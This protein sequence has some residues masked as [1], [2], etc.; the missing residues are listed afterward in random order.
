M[1]KDRDI[2][3]IASIDWDFIWQ[4]HQE[5]MATFAKNGNRVLFIENTGVRVP[6]IRDIGRLRKRLINWIKGVKGFREAHQNLY[7]YSP[8][9]L[10]FPYS[11]LARWINR[12]FL[13]GTLRKWLKLMDFNDAVVWTFLPTGTALDIIDDLDYKCLVYYCIADF[14][15]LVKKPKKV[16]KTE[17]A[18]IRKSDIIFAQGKAF[19]E[20]CRSL[21]DN[22]Y[23]F[24]FGLNTGIFDNS[25]EC[26]RDY[27]YSDIKNVKNPIIGYIGGIHRHIDFDLLEYIAGANSHWS[28]VLVGPVQTDVSSLKEFPNIFFLGKKN[29]NLLPAY[30]KEFDVCIIPYI[31]SEFT[32]TVYPTKLN[33]YHALGKP[34][35]S[36]DL[37][38]IIEFNRENGNLILIAS[39]ND[40]FVKLIQQALKEQDNRLV[41]MRIES[42]KRHSWDIRIE[43]MS[44]LI[45]E[46]IEKKK[47]SGYA[48]W[49]KKFKELYRLAR[50]RLVKLVLA[51][52]ALWLIVFY[53]P[54]VWFLAE[55][56]KIIN[57][58]SKA[59]AI[60]VFAGGVGESG[61]A[62]QGY[63][64]RVKHAA[65]LYNS[66]YARYIIFSSGFRSTFSEP[67]IMQVL[68]ISLGVPRDF[69]I[70][71]TKAG[72]TYQNVVFTSAILRSKGWNKIILVSSPYHT[73]RAAL[74]F[75][76]IVNDISV[77]FSPVPNSIFYS[78]N[79][80]NEKGKRIWK[81]INLKQIRGI[82]HEYLGIIYYWWKHYI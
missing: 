34:V 80:F 70:L 81:K 82:I 64:E 74:V 5:I 21:N 71:E 55:P 20:K 62:G 17:S 37:S 23:I 45:E 41:Q 24:P 3:C 29:F 12:Y 30:I 22:V 18:L 31:N 63:E 19:E 7:V 42:A 75:K 6:G 78:R 47:M 16:Q 49:Q 50:R 27:D 43:E 35:V 9:I 10:P 57:P 72:N 32:K 56:L 76:K 73:R 52:C 44:D 69:I 4:G 51:V 65:E 53:T 46:N 40:G 1:L 33:E 2:I 68:A 79:K 59:D 77:I 15:E 14:N 66:G 38:E 36:T 11:R 39:S 54:L 13:F 25:K 61:Q 8:L 26:S 28:I 60:V 48:G 58:P 67:Y